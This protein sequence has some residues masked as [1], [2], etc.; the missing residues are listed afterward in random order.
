MDYAKDKGFLD[1]LMSAAEKGMFEKLKARLAA[2]VNI[3]EEDY[4]SYQN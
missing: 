1:R 3:D 2:G 4:V